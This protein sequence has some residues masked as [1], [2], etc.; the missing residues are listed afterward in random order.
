MYQYYHEPILI[1]I[2]MITLAG[3]VASGFFY[4][5]YIYGNIYVNVNIYVN[6]YVNVYM[7]K[8]QTNKQNK[9]R[10]R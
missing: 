7:C 4:Q 1:L 2:G 3:Y 6:N 8:K 10:K 5:M 9:T